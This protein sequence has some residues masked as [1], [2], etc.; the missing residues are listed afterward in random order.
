MYVESSDMQV[1]WTQGFEEHESLTCKHPRGPIPDP[2][3][4]VGHLHSTY[5]ELIAKNK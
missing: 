1:P 2:V 3:Y 4:P 5:V